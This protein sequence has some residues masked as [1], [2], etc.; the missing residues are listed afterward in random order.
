MGDKIPPKPNPVSVNDAV[1]TTAAA[2]TGTRFNVSDSTEIVA[3]K[4]GGV[5]GRKLDKLIELMSKSGE[6]EIVIKID[7][8]EVGRAALSSMNNDFYG[9]DLHKG[10][11]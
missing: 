7:R 6:K 5:L 4:E 1:I 8:R 9:V 11:V 10:I 3:S 2:Q